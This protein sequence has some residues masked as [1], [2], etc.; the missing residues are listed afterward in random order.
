[1][2]AFPGR[3]VG[4]DCR[5]CCPDFVSC[6]KTC[7]SRHRSNC[8]SR[9]VFAV[10]AYLAR[11]ALVGWAWDLMSAE[12][13]EMSSFEGRADGRRWG[14]SQCHVP[15]RFL[16]V[17]AGR[18]RCSG[19]H[20]HLHLLLELEIA[21]FVSSALLWDLSLLL[22]DLAH[23]ARRAG[24]PSESLPY[25]PIS[26]P[27]VVV[28]AV[29]LSQPLSSRGSQSLP[30][31]LDVSTSSARGLRHPDRVLRGV[32]PALCPCY[33]PH[34]YLHGFSGGRTNLADC[35]LRFRFGFR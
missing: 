6:C 26:S 32:C 5:R 16:L 23:Q 22:P 17:F 7:R 11:C 33:F 19:P 30:T 25:W 21:S 8:H 4:L 20:H 35:L 14:N 31:Y 29:A 27:S 1:M 3:R 24:V 15:R 13:F 10:G 34:S 9:P 18:S 28:V 2:L 12:V